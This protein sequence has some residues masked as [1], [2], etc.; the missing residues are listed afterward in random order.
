MTETAQSPIADR[1]T[2]L[3]QIAAERERQASGLM[4]IRRHAAALIAAGT[5]PCEG[6]VNEWLRDHGI[7][8]TY[9][10]EEEA[11]RYALERVPGVQNAE[12]YS[13]LGL[14]RQLREMQERAVQWLGSFRTALLRVQRSE[15]LDQQRVGAL[16]AELGTPV[17][18]VPMVR[19]SFGVELQ[20]RAPVTSLPG[21]ATDAII[22]AEAERRMRDTLMAM[23]R[24]IREGQWELDS[25][26]GE[27][28]LDVDVTIT[29]TGN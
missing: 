12:E 25:E 28:C 27:L 3:A 7:P 2:V 29:R 11:R 21:G 22:R 10:S 19:L 9:G 13:A 16:L 1:E 5:G 26:D 6:G 23:T 20:L 15:R 17:E 14:Q 4:T 24:G 8:A 18:A